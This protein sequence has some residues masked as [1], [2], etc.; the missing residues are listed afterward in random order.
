M[1]F[2]EESNVNRIPRLSLQSALIP[3]LSLAERP[4]N[5]EAHEYE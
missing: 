5:L 4:S 3:F 1:L 2:S